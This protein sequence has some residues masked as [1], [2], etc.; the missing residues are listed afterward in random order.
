[1]ILV[2]YFNLVLSVLICFVVFSCQ[3]DKAEDPVILTG[4]EQ[5]NLYIPKLE[6]KSVALLVNHTSLIGGVHLLDTLLS[7]GVDVVKIFAPEHGFRGNLANGE[8]VHDD[9]DQKTGLPLVS[10]YGKNKKPSSEQLNGI[11]VVIY[12]I[13]DVGAR[14][15]TYISSM[16]HMMEACAKNGITFML[17]DRP[18]PNAHYI[19]GPVLEK[20][21][22]SFVG[23]H[24]I[25]IVY[26]MTTG[27]L[28]QM[29]K[30]ESWINESEALDLTI[31]ELKNWT[32]TSTYELPISPSPNLPNRQSIALYPSLCLFEGTDISMGRGT[33]FPFQAVGYPDSVF[34][35]FQFT[36]RRIEGVS[37]YPPHKNKTCYGDDLR[38]VNPPNRIDL[39][40]LIKYYQLSKNKANYFN[41]FFTNL[42]GTKKLRKQIEEGWS[43]EEIRTS[44]Q[45]DLNHF[46]EKRQQYLI[47]E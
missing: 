14:F 23:V 33:D 10:L 2:K 17:L 24:P 25:P 44:W 6:G 21:H 8:Q 9:R 37:K 29:V 7:S 45:D 27:E 18:N 28:A 22:A 4:A 31:V 40:Y 30:G 5:V 1:M 16:H 20:A 12:D 42:S 46:K 38:T 47:Y 39:S 19:D 3:A 34:G 26:G 36:P 41:A 43:E 32:H 13:Q 11:D 15:Y 35:E